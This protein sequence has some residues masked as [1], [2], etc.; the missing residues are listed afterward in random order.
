M[1]YCVEGC[2]GLIVTKTVKR[3]KKNARSMR[4]E[5][6]TSLVL[7][8]REFIVMVLKYVNDL[9][10]KAVIVKLNDKDV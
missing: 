7:N 6:K 3:Q 9:I 4:N 10:R 1:F 5:S 2:L 8:S